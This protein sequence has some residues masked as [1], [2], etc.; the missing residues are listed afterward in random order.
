MLVSSILYPI[1]TLFYFTCVYVLLYSHLPVA[2]LN[3]AFGEHNVHLWGFTHVW[4]DDGHN[5][6]PE[7]EPSMFRIG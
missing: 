5:P 4:H 6:Q 3:T 1:S 7:Y 2:W